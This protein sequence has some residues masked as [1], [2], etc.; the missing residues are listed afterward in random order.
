MGGGALKTLKPS[1]EFPQ[2]SQH[3]TLQFEV[4]STAGGGVQRVHHTPPPGSSARLSAAGSDARACFCYCVQAS[5]QRSDEDRRQ[6]NQGAR[7]C[8]RGCPKQQRRKVAMRACKLRRP[9][10]RQLATDAKAPA[11]PSSKAGARTNI[12]ACHTC[13]PKGS[14]LTMI[15]GKRAPPCPAAR[16]EVLN[17]SRRHRHRRSHGRHHNRHHHH[18]PHSH[19]HHGH[20]RHSHHHRRSHGRHHGRQQHHHRPEAGPR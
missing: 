4:L 20:H 19:H 13:T 3:P 17:S 2:A 14:V 9:R 8:A 12:V 7:S 10:W 16:Q 5:T 1:P 6:P 15:N 11:Q 18:D